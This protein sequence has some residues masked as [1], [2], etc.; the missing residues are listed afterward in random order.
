MD[1]VIDDLTGSGIAK[2]LR[3]HGRSAAQHAPPEST[4]VLDI[5]ELRKPDITFWSV[6]SE[7]ELVGCGALKELSSQHGEIK[8]M[9]TV[10]THRRRGVAA[11]VLEHILAE[12]S[13]RKY[14]RVSLETGSM[15]AFSPARKLYS[16]FGFKKC[17]PFADYVE[18]PHSSFMTKD[19]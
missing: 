16:S 19:L 3:E 8:S 9:H 17:G 15:E 6:W 11:R 7:A 4:H 2:L 10:P 5:D 14:T 12:A 18:D 1:I 13:R